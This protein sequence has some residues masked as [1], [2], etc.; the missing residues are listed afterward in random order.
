LT[1]F[2]SPVQSKQE[3][4]PAEFVF[5]LSQDIKFSKLKQA[6]FGKSLE[7]EQQEAP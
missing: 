1:E 6:L 7:Q 5:A 2:S 4:H 3:L